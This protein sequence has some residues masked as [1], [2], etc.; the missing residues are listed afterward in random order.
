MTVLSDAPH[1]CL[2]C[3]EHR[4]EVD[5]PGGLLDD[6][7]VITFHRPPL[8]EALVYA[9]HLLVTSKRHAADFAALNPDEAA[10]VGAAVSTYSGALKKLGATRVYVATIGHHVDHLHVHL[11][12]RWPD[13]PEDVPW[14]S[15]DSWEGARRVAAHEVEELVSELR[16]CACARALP[17]SG[18][19]R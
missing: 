12:P 3:R 14:H 17:A 6:G 1:A 4:G 15:I 9:G 8:D 10:A 5:V 11:L 19:L 13:T 2:I 16:R 7:L 18:G